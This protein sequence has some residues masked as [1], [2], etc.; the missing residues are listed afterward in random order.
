MGVT[1]GRPN[2]IPP[3]DKTNK[4]IWDGRRTGLSWSDTIKLAMAPSKNNGC[5]ING[6]IC[7]GVAVSID[8]VTDF[9]E[10]QSSIPQYLICDGKNHWKASYK[11]D[12]I[13]IYNNNDDTANMRWSC[14]Q[15]NSQKGGHKGL[16]E[17]VPQWLRACPGTGV[18]TYTVRGEQL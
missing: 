16:Y 8:H 6:P 13:A 5:Q 15:C 10:L 1:G 7:N 12:A 3:K 9:A 18:C 11:E 17:N 2:H 4:A 14:T